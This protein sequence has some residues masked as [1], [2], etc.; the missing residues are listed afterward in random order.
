MAIELAERFAERVATSGVGPSVAEALSEDDSS[1][2][3]AAGE[4][5][6]RLLWDCPWGS[7]LACFVAGL[8]V[9]P[10]S[11]L[12]RLVRLSWQR[13]VSQAERRLLVRVPERP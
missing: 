6:L 4:L 3:P 7:H 2:C 13:L 11:D 9:W 12:L 10:L 1:I 5:L 8:L